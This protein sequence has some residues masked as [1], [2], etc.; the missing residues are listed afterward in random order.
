VQTR[1]RAIDSSLAGMLNAAAPLCTALVAAVWA[2]TLP[3]RR[4][5]AGL[6]VGF[7][8]VVGVYL[9]TLGGAESTAVGVGLVLLATYGV[10][11]NLTARLQPRTAP[12][13]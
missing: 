11:F 9:P 8:G 13:R 10:A 6:A 7:A 4:R 12:C 3:D 5:V 2:R 1:G